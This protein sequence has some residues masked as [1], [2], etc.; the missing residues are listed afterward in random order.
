[1]NNKKDHLNLLCDISELT[2]LLAENAN[3][4]I[5]LQQVASLIFHHL[6]AQICSIYLFEEDSDE[7]VLKATIGLNPA[8]IGKV[9]IKLGQGL[10]GDSL[11]HSR[12]VCE[13]DACQDSNYQYF[14]ETKETG[15]FSFLAVPIQRSD[16]KIGVL[17]V[18][19]QEQ[20][21]FNELDAMALRALAAQ[22]AGAIENA[23]IL[24]D[25]YRQAKEPL[26]SAKFNEFDIIKGEIGS[27]GYA[28]A[29]AAIFKRNLNDFFDKNYD[30]DNHQTLDDFNQAV[31][32]TRDQLKTLQNRFAAQLP[33]S[34]SLIFSA[35]FMILKDPSFIGE[36][37][38]Q[39]SAGTSPATAVRSIAQKYISLFSSS[40]HAYIREKVN[41]V[42]DLSN[43]I[44]RNLRH[45]GET[46]NFFNKKRIVIAQSL[47]PS[48]VLKFVSENVQG[49]ILVSGGITSHV[50][51][52][53]QSLQVP[54][55]IADNP[56]LLTL[57][58]ETPVLMDAE[59]GNIY[60]H[61]S[62]T[63]M[64]HFEARNHAAT[65]AAKRAHS[66]TSTTRTQD[67][68]RVSLM[69]NINLLSELPVAKNLKAEGVGLYRTEFPF[70][71]R[72]ILPSEEEQFQIYKH[73]IDEMAGCEVTIRT[74][75]AGGDKLLSQFNK[76]G[77]SNPQLGFRSI[78]FSLQHQEIFKNQ[79]RAILKAAATSKSVRLMFPMI[80][81]LDEFIA[82]RQIVWDCMDD[83]ARENQPYA[84]NLSIG[85][86]AEIPSVIEIMDAF[87][88]EADFFSIGTND[89]VQY[90]L[91]VDRTNEKVKDYYQPWHPSILRGL[92]KIVTAAI[93][94]KKDISVCGEMAH[95]P[96]FL[97]FLLGIGVRC[98]S[99][100]PLFLPDAQ[101]RIA[102]MKISNA[103]K[104]AQALA[105]ET[106]ISGIQRIVANEKQ[107]K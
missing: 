33:E 37:V 3:I 46:N 100:S 28:F 73:L 89:F 36:M 42:E 82:A 29:P 1:M 77:E 103:E 71:I 60:I 76:T 67:G 65:I 4:E 62:N 61:P 99:V 49:I 23:R 80:S 31:Q 96:A 90:S 95:D 25:G 75:D 11:K 105:A 58:D 27:K 54:L 15:Y 81:S 16:E 83:L 78:R 52:L 38:K 55:I 66:M 85:M 13:G 91:A 40:T 20:F 70:L 59:F 86:M 32:S 64:Q 84:T 53:S 24:M 79:I 22:L 94:F 102:R 74:L 50:S 44:L 21:F 92:I 10:I 41:D 35:H 69:A 19:H 8:A 48:D 26:V 14:A 98:L 68:V 101:Q 107:F 63:V 30:L 47:F 57:P 6:N 106:T 51:I 18:Q 5:F 72:T 97:I 9:R 93:A 39:I 12:V 2:N 88:Q 56:S 104:F 17:V 7:L 34:A 43:R 87:A 45:K